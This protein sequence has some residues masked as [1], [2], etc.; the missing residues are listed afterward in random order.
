MT[1]I[2]HAPHDDYYHPVP[3]VVSEHELGLSFPMNAELPVRARDDLNPYPPPLEYADGRVVFRAPHA[4]EL[5]RRRA[6]SLQEQIDELR[7]SLPQPVGYVVATF[8]T[9]NWDDAL[10]GL[11]PGQDRGD[12]VIASVF[13]AQTIARRATTTGSCADARVA[14]VYRWSAVPT[15]AESGG[16]GWEWLPTREGRVARLQELRAELRTL[17]P[18]RWTGGKHG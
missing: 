18:T 5:S 6:L 1:K 7:E 10:R 3:R 14:V 4:A 16:D 13:W 9:P 17:E 2:T 15:I 12:G 11:P 8:G